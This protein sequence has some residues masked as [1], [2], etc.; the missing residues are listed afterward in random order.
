MVSPLWMKHK[1]RNPY[2]WVSK[3]KPR[4]LFPGEQWKAQAVLSGTQDFCVTDSP[5]LV[6]VSQSQ[7]LQR[8]RCLR[9]PPASAS[10]VVWASGQFLY[11]PRGFDWRIQTRSR[12]ESD[13]Y[14]YW[15]KLSDLPV[16]TLYKEVSTRNIFFMAQTNKR[17]DK[18]IN[19]NL[20]NY[21]FVVLRNVN[22]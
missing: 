2:L 12:K 17:H 1:S 5:E 18:R 22:M 20:Q 6:H 11:I 21:I 8:L 10:Q 19:Y 15:V 13:G 3:C 4:V 14:A 7:Q 9:L 16:K